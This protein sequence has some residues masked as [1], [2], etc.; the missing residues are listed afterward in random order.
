MVHGVT[1]QIGQ[2]AQH[3][4]GYPLVPESATAPLADLVV[5]PAWESTDKIVVAMTTSPSA[6][7]GIIYDCTFVIW[8]C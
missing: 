4:L 5:C 2:S 8:I 7:V 3:A 6:Q 1:G